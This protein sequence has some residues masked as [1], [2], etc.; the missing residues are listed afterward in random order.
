MAPPSLRSDQKEFARLFHRRIASIDLKF[1]I[2]VSQVGLNRVL[3]DMKG[4]GNCAYWLGRREVFDDLKL[5][6]RQIF[7]EGAR[8]L[9]FALYSLRDQAR[10]FL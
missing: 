10:K 6:T 4:L 5:T 7:L 3:G 2:H 1:A 9:V 8:R